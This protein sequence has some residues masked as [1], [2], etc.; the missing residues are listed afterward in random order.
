MRWISVNTKLPD[1]NKNVLLAVENEE[2]A[3]F[4]CLVKTAET[5]NSK[6]YYFNRFSDG[7]EGGIEEIHNKVTHWGVLPALPKPE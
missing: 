2:E 7:I 3:S 4:G 5:A 6:D 1:Y